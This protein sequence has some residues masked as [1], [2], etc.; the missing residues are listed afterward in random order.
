[1][2]AGKFQTML[3][4][5]SAGSSP[6]LVN[7]PHAGCE[8]PEELLS[9]W[10]AAGRDLVDTDW[11]VHRLVDFASELGAG[12]LSAR[13]SRYVIDLNRAADDQ[14]L[15]SGPVTGLVPT[16]TF[17]GDDLYPEAPPDSNEVAQRI[18]G[19]WRP[20][21]ER[22]ANELETIR[23][24]HGFAVLLDAH[25]IRSRVPRFFEGQLPDLNLGT[26]DGR[27]CDPALEQGAAALMKRHDEFSHV[28]NGRFKGG[29]IT[30]HYGRPD[31]N[32]H[33]L[34]LEIAQSCYMDESQPER[35]DEARARPLK[36]F[37]HDLVDYLIEWRP[38]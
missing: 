18:E 3:F 9:R 20:Y 25:S 8:A 27:S 33:A 32:I 4:N 17:G 28:I 24:R 30:R 37:L 31:E 12:V 6:V 36:H 22:L 10:S 23:S 1:M 35:Y 21:H 19:Y 15:Y 2:V 11:H 13:V 26:F 16:E 7:V 34:Q 5:Y 14:P 29:Y 38:Q